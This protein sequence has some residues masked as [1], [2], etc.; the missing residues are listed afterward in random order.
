MKKIFVKGLLTLGILGVGFFSTNAAAFADYPPQH[1]I[2]SVVK[3][4]D[5]P[6]QH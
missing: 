6:P 4:F 5:Y 2:S 3:P 1:S